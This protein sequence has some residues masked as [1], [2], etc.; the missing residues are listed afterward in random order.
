MFEKYF[1]TISIEAKT[2]IEMVNQQLIPACARDLKTYEG[3]SLAGN[4]PK[5]YASLMKVVG[6]LEDAYAAIP[7]GVEVS[8]EAHYA[9]EKLVPLMAAVREV[10]DNIELVMEKGVYPFPSYAE[11]LLGHH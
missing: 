2:M 10:A 4:R 6:D 11:V 9:S 7:H 5:L 8:K 1:L 3:T